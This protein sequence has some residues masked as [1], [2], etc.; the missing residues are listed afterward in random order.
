MTK[1]K[2]GAASGP[3]V[4]QDGIFTMA[5]TSSIQRRS[6]RNI[7][8][9]QTLDPALPGV[10]DVVVSVEGGMV[11]RCVGSRECCEVIT[12]MENVETNNL[13][14]AAVASLCKIIHQC[15]ATRWIP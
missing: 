9:E 13:L 8:S 15:M 6:G 1:L 3:P 4:N 14:S 7:N 5:R 11:V 12:E 10:A 2:L